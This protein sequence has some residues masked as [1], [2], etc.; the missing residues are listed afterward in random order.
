MRKLA[1]GAAPLALGG[2]SECAA[3]CGAKKVLSLMWERLKQLVIAGWQV[4]PLARLV[5]LRS[6]KVILVCAMVR[7]RTYKVRNVFVQPA[8]WTASVKLYGGYFPVKPRS[9]W[10]SS[11]RGA[12]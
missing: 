12:G 8:S 3:V 9:C 4:S 6:G 7:Q 11:T 1:L 10:N 5:T 2:R